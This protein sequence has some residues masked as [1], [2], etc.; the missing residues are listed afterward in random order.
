MISNL[1]NFVKRFWPLSIKHEIE[2][3][4]NVMRK[5]NA[6]QEVL[7]LRIYELIEAEKVNA[8]QLHLISKELSTTS[9]TLDRYVKSEQLLYENNEL[10]G[11]YRVVDLNRFVE[12]MRGPDLEKCYINLID[13]LDGESKKTV[14]MIH[15]RLDKISKSAAKSINLYTQKEK[16]ELRRQDEYLR[17]NRFQLSDTCF[18]TGEFLLPVEYFDR[19]VFFDLHCKNEINNLNKTLNKCI[20]DAGA[21]IGDSALVL[22]KWTQK[23]IYC[24]EAMSKNFEL[25]TKTIKMN[26]IENAV[27]VKLALGDKAGKLKFHYFDYSS[28]CSVNNQAD[29]ETED[30]EVVTLDDYV[31]ENNLDVGLIK[32]DIEGSEQMFLQGA[33]KTIC[34]QRPILLISIYHKP[35]DFYYIKPEIERW[36]LGYTFKI[37]KPISKSVIIGTVLIAETDKK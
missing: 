10:D 29:V 22:S 1:K 35:E 12:F 31:C 7:R 33:K 16:D 9:K 21:Y 19:T 3:Y 13:A 23:N 27:P 25:L 37:H 6:I 36:N 15:N 4:K 18:S 30:V 24:F 28:T 32:V 5:L 8:K 17:S 34:E 20:I 14:S 2:Q 26:N 11:K